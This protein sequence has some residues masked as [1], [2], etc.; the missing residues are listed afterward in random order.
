VIPATKHMPVET[1]AKLRA[2]QQRGG[3]VIYEA[4]P[5]DVPGLGKLEE[6]RKQFQ[7]DRDII[8]RR[9]ARVG[10]VLA[11]LRQLAAVREP[12]AA[13]G[14]EFIRRKNDRGWS[15][16]LVNL[17]DQPFDSWCAL[18]TTA[19]AIELIDPL[20]GRSGSAALSAGKNP[21]VYLQ[22]APGESVLL[23]TSSSVPLLG[24]AAYPEKTDKKAVPPVAW[25]YTTPA[26]PPLPL[27]G[28]WQVTFLSGGPEL[29]PPF[30]TTELKSWTELGEEPAQAFGGTARYQL[31]FTLTSAKK[32]DDWLLD[33]GDVRE[34]A[35]VRL[36][37]QPV[38]TAWSV[39]FHVRL[40][41]RLKP[42]RNVL[43]I[44]VTNLAANRIR[45]LDR[46]Q[47][48]WKV[49]REINFVNINY[50]PFDA[51]SWPLTPSGL[52]GG[53][54]LTPLQAPAM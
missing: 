3:A 26:A 52:L 45:D 50:K 5:E 42:G 2:L 53:V 24:H 36:N 54:T 32:G 40:G 1:L 47:V 22:L 41:D 28:E 37:G 49:M 17:T 15:Y 44:D 27:A 46:R 29:P 35:R 33:L 51:A 23:R 19:D 48:S 13:T 8:V 6:R 11:T 43:E 38:A 20:T 31:V 34:S 4:L 18:G 12:L 16:F 21:Q 10:K 25:V 39:P 9:D 7:F 30:K 14:L